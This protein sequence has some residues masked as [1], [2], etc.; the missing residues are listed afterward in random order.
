[1]RCSKD[2]TTRIDGL[3]PVDY[4][5][6][7]LDGHGVVHDWARC[8]VRPKGQSACLLSFQ[9]ILLRIRNPRNEARG[10]ALISA[11]QGILKKTVLPMNSEQEMCLPPGR[12]Q[13]RDWSKEESLGSKSLDLHLQGVPGRTVSLPLR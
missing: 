1:H 13:L 3:W 11:R 10:F 4:D 2:G 8:R 9:A 5:V 12:Y 7:L 6:V